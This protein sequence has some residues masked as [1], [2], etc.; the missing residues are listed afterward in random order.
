[1]RFGLKTIVLALAAWLIAPVIGRAQAPAPY[2]ATPELIEAARKDA[3][4]VWYTSTD[5]AVSEKMAAMFE[6]KYPGIK[7]QVERAGAE[8]VFQRI[9]QEYSSGIKNADVIETS[10]A[11]HFVVFKRQGW[12][13][14]VVP[15]DVAK[16]WPANVREPDGFFAAYRAHLSVMG[17]NTKLVKPT[18]V[19]KSHTDLLDPKWRGKMVKAHPGYSG[20]IMTDTFALS[21]ALGWDY[22]VK[23]G[24]Q[25]VMQVQSST[26]PPKKLALGERAVMADGNEYGVFMLKEK[27][28][29]IEPIYAID[30]STI[31][32]G[33]AAVLKD[34]TRPSAARLFYAF[35]FT[36]EAQ[37]QM[38]D[39]GGLR[40]FHP[41]V[42]EKA[43]RR[44]L[45][46]IKVLYTDPA[47]LEPEVENIK[48][49]YEAAFG[50]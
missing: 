35:M 19:P 41:G 36:Q 47:K 30:G 6:G 29:P 37:Q 12:L 17:Y 7:V 11:V 39:V 31:A 3:K 21:E 28:D 22:L 25:R 1:M 32:I 43:G 23:L 40:S 20:S 26:E 13:A 8:R 9:S 24:Q 2:E 34:S 50:T 38:S 10:D 33:H 4:V 18:D 44:P 46:E 27:G 16:S 15:V 14:Q 48:K 42:K 5:V 45:S 49:K